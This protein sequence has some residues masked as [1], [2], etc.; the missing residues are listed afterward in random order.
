KALDSQGKVIGEL[1]EQ[2]PYQ[3]WL[4]SDFKDKKSC[5]ACHMPVVTEEVPITGVLGKAREGFSR[6]TFVGGNFLIQRMLNRYRT[7]LS[8]GALPQEL[9]AA[10]SRTIAHLQSEAARISIDRVETAGGRLEADVTVENK[11]GHKL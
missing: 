6:H 1:P 3:E 10:A 9:E 4:A 5:Q 7:E 11:S 8:T 2:V